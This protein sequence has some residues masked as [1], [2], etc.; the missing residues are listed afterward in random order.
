MFPNFSSDQRNVRL[1]LV[2]D[3]FNPFGTM[4]LSYSM[5]LVILIPY[6]VP[7]LRTMTASSFMMALLIL[8]SDSSGRDIDVYL[9]PLIDELK[10]LWEMGFET[11]DCVSKKNS[12]TVLCLCGQWLTFLRTCTY[13]VGVQVA[14]KHVIPARK[15]QLLFIWET[16]Y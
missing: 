3:G 16:S 5:W 2:S 6:D 1:G 10:I 15:I 14:T 12:T 9:R 11:Y 7:P 13:V 8:G 4:S